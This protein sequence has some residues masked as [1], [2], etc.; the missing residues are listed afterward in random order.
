MKSGSRKGK[1]K[2]GTSGWRGIISKDFTVKNLAITVQAIAIYLKKS[3]VDTKKGV[4]VGY[5]TRFMSDRFAA[6]A[7]GILRNN[8]IPVL[9]TNRDTPTPA[10]AFQI[11]R[12]H[13]AGAI[14]ITASH[15]PAEYNG[16][17][18]S[19][20][21]GG[22]AS[23][24]ETR[25]IE[26]EANKLLKKDITPR[27]QLDKNN[28]KTFD[29]RPAYLK[30][31][32]S[33]VNLDLIRK[34]RIKLAIDCLYGTS[35]GYLDYI[36]N[37]NNIPTI[38]INDNLNP[39]FAGH[40]PNPEPE[41]LHDLK[42]IVMQNKTRLGLATDG[43][44]D[45][46][47][48]LDSNGRYISPNYILPL[49]LEHLLRTRSHK[50]GIV[51]SITTTHLLDAIAKHFGRRIYE[52]PVGFKYVGAA[53]TKNNALMGGE[54]SGGMTI[55]NHIPDKDGILACLLVAELTAVG[56]KSL[57][58]LLADLRKRYGDFFSR[59]TDIKL[60]PENMGTI[61]TRLKNKPAAALAGITISRYQ[62]LPGK[63]FKI[64]LSEGSW[65]IIRPSGTEPILRC[66]LETT[67]LKN[68]PRLERAIRNLVS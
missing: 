68:I 16:I 56:K 47:G 4:I 48:I 52:V 34:S 32:S 41:Y 2:F 6:I 10:I 64:E 36:L 5:D 13:T 51:R 12:R 57:T 15:N 50:G 11:L 31:I 39:N 58:Q 28:I 30:H 14:N 25:Q 46:F 49:I 67:A 8:R 42:N 3:G 53:L 35:R 45:R 61:L 9:L 20:A 59:R 1:I 18:F 33:I 37:E 26:K 55:F 40:G 43:D 65:I 38:T 29:P 60:K 54:E 7:A 17:K 66:Y 19:P 62:A 27:Y 21:Y 22:P 63:N 23:G 44:G 24:T